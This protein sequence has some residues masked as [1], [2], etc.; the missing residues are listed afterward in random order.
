[1]SRKRG[2]QFKITLFIPLFTPFPAPSLEQ[3]QMARERHSR[4]NGPIQKTEKEK[5]APVHS[6]YNARSNRPYAVP[7]P[8]AAPR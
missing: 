8:S 5:A 2:D 3:R 6:F 7:L 4:D 1:M